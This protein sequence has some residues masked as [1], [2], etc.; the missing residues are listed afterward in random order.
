[1][2]PTPAPPPGWGSCGR[3]AGGGVRGVSP[4][5]V[6]VRLRVPVPVYVYGRGRA[7]PTA[8]RLLRLEP[9]ARAPLQPGT[10]LARRTMKSHRTPLALAPARGRGR[11]G[12][13]EGPG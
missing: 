7:A 3:T 2:R 6:H 1:G 12:V 10:P 11:A 9:G 13:A 8:V 4:V 5:R